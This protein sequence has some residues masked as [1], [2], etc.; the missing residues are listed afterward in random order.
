MIRKIIFTIIASLAAV[1]SGVVIFSS[2]DGDVYSRSMSEQVAAVLYA[3]VYS[4]FFVLNVVGC[5]F[6]QKSKFL[7]ALV[8]GAHGIACVFLLALLV[9]FARDG[10]AEIAVVLIL[11]YAVFLWFFIA[12]VRQKPNNSVQPTAARSASSGG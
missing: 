5:W 7:R 4:L 8:I 12:C 11:L 6:W 3:S 10:G 9:S 1:W 2:P